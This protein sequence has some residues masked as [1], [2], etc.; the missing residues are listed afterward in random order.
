MRR[1]GQALVL[2]LVGI[3]AVAAGAFLAIALYYHGLSTDLRA[4]HAGIPASLRA[5]LAPVPGAL[6][7]AQVTLVRASGTSPSG[8][9]VIFRTAPAKQ[10]VALLAIP[11][12]ATLAGAPVRT[13][14]TMELI[15]GLRFT[16]GIG[17]SHLVV[18]D[19]DGSKQRALRVVAG[20]ILAPA[21]VT[22]VRPAARAIAESASDLSASDILALLWA[23]QHERRALRC[24][25]AG[26]RPID[27]V[28][29]EAVVAAFLMRRS[30]GGASA[31]S[32]RAVAPASVIP[33]EAL[34]AAVQRYGAWVFGL[35][36]AAAM[37][38]SM[39][40]ATVFARLRI[41]P[42]TA[43]PALTVEAAS[44]GSTLAL[45]SALAA[46]VLVGAA[47]AIRHA[48]AVATPR[49][50][51]SGAALGQA[52]RTAVAAGR[53]GLERLAEIRDEDR[54]R[55]RV[56]RFVYL[57]QDAVWIGLCAAIAAGILIR[58]LAS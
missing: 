42:G 7:D 49:A 6:D 10:A 2:A 58:L 3:G 50:R 9:V 17:I 41:A 32:A 23:R 36:A 38:G 8:G 56:R 39:G 29:G 44:G 54:R 24:A 21:G 27:S 4:A 48:L 57:H 26:R 51:V 11:G 14:D 15:H 33:P 46:P 25:F 55:S 34:L 37:L 40:L 20:E 22:D 5:V 19:R 30:H 43:G 47:D 52:A 13:L 16:M 31:C 1:L 18:V 53:E 35:L 28:Q 12:S 45:R